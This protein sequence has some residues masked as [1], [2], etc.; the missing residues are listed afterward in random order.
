M[1]YLPLTASH[2]HMLLELGRLQARRNQLK[3]NLLEKLSMSIVSSVFVLISTTRPCWMNMLE[4]PCRNTMSLMWLWLV[5]RTKPCCQ[6]RFS[7]AT[8]S[9]FSQCYSHKESTSFRL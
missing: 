6:Q 5:G 1:G 8:L 9:K 2:I 3:Q 4:G 7:E